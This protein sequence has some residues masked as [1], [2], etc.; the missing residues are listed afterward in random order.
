M[1]FK[2]DRTRS[3][4]KMRLIRGVMTHGALGNSLY[5]TWQMFNMAVKTGDLCFMLAAG[6]FYI[7]W[8][9]FMAFYTV[10][11]QQFM[12]GIQGQ[13]FLCRRLELRGTFSCRDLSGLN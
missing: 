10:G 7:G 9:G 8:F 2:A 12:G 1:A 5:S 11:I 6:P 13:D 4:G 3:K